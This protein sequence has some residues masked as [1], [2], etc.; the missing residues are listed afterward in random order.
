MLLILVNEVK[1]YCNFR[2]SC[3][4]SRCCVDGIITAINITVLCGYL[5]PAI[6]IITT[7]TNITCY[8]TIHTSQFYLLLVI[9]SYIN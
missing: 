3:F 8:F 9:L 1:H 2:L 4:Q 5:K 7:I 6:N